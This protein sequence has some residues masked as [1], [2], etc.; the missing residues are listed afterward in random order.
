MKPTVYSYK[1]KFIEEIAV[2]LDLN[3]IRKSSG[4]RMHDA[5][6]GS[7]DYRVMQRVQLMHVCSH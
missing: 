5:A 2:A 7:G 3:I 6:S 1:W 4:C